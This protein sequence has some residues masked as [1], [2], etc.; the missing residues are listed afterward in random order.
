[1]APAP[2]PWLPLL[3]REEVVQ[4]GWS[5]WTIYWGSYNGWSFGHGTGWDITSVDG[6][7]DMMELKNQDAQLLGDGE[8]FGQDWEKKRIITMELN[9]SGALLE[10]CFPQQPGLL[11]PDQ[12]MA[13][14]C[15]LM[16]RGDQGDLPLE[17]NDRWVVMARPRK[18][19]APQ[20]SAEP[21]KLTVSW[22]AQDP[23][24]YSAVEHEASATLQL[25]GQGR[26][27]PFDW[28]DWDWQNPPPGR[29]P[30]REGYRFR[31]PAGF[32]PDAWTWRYLGGGTSG[33]M[34]LDNKGCRRT[35]LRFRLNGPVDRPMLINHNTGQRVEFSLELGH[36]D[37]LEVDMRRGIVNLN[38]TVSRYYALTRDSNWW[39]L[40][41]GITPVR[42]LSRGPVY[43]T[44]RVTVWWR[45]A[46]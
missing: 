44:S 43:P 26:P 9:G 30:I 41:P 27:Y 11:P 39:A 24:L 17:I 45:D 10:R 20:R 5:D 13:A 29:P 25:Q 18:F 46:W 34:Q 33:L 7:A 32:E 42:F 22:E 21:P 3:S 6:W 19:V 28:T 14:R 4:E 31:G 23:A 1:M 40:E 38:G 35:F 2:N 36:R 37:W 8:V 12:L 16:R 15:A